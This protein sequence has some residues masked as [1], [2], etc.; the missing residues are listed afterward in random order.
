MIEWEYDG[1]EYTK[2]DFT[3]VPEGEYEVRIKEAKEKVS[4]TG[5]NMIVMTLNLVELPQYGSLFYN[6]VFD[7]A[8][9]GMTNQRLGRVYDSFGITQGNLDPYTWAGYRGV[10]RVKHRE[11]EGKTRAEV[12]SFAPRED[13]GDVRPY[14]VPAK[15]K[16]PAKAKEKKAPEKAEGWN[17][18]E[19]GPI[20]PDGISFEE[21]EADIP[22]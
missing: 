13:E 20:D 15:E 21:D 18:K 2:D 12:E 5:K 19:S 7:P 3:L 1:R 17:F 14:P 10:A 11:F 9:P 16:A 4:K 8:Y 22:F 6:L